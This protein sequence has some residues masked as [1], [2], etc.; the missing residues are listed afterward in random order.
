MTAPQI[1]TAS[2]AC[3]ALAAIGCAWR[4][5]DQRLIALYPAFFSY[6][7]SQA[8]L[9]SVSSLA[10]TRSNFYAW[11]FIFAYPVSWVVYGLMVRELYNQIFKNFPGIAMFGRLSVYLAVALAGVIAVLSRAATSR[12]LTKTSAILIP[13]EVTG[14]N[15]VFGLALS[16]IVLLL[17][18]SRYPIQLHRNVL[19]NCVVFGAWLLA[20]A[21]L[22]LAE[23]LTNLNRTVPLDV[24][25][26]VFNIGCF[27]VW[28]FLLSPQ[29]ATRFIHIHHFSP[30][31]ERRL[32]G[33]LDSL[34]ALGVRA[35]RK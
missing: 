19:V 28:G 16:I 5:Y 7:I 12:V 30:K 9:V 20:E 25:L 22:M 29:G 14:R 8:I 3:S 35:S 31:D 2:S 18:I 21:T 17:L 32:M 13:L 4:V 27:A 23:H 26:M 24:A 34:N 11:L 15:V 33:Q 1:L 10:D 6:L